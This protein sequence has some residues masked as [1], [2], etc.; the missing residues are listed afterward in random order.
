L[1]TV[2]LKLFALTFGYRFWYS[3]KHLRV[4]TGFFEEPRIWS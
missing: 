4:E 3:V 1:R 2:V